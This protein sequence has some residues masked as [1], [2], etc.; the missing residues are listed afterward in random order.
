VT[1]AAPNRI[2]TSVPAGATTGVIHVVTP[3]GSADS[4]TPFTVGGDVTVSP[5]TVT[6]Y[7]TAS[8]QFA[9]SEGAS[10]TTTVTWAVNGITGG[11]PQIG[12]ITATGLYTAPAQ[13]RMDTDVTVAATLQDD[14]TAKATATV[15]LLRI[16]QPVAAAVSVLVAPLPV[17]VSQNLVAGV[18]VRVAESPTTLAAA[19][20]VGVAF[21]PVVTGVSP[22]SS[23]AG[24]SNL[25]MT[26]SGVGLTAATAVEFFRTNVAD[27]GFTVTNVSANAEGTE[28]TATVS[29]AGGAPSGPRV[30][31][32][33]TPGGAST[34]AGST[35]SLFSVP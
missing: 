26:I 14:R 20:I 28:V 15:R 3:L 30:V 33:T 1:A 11:E 6:L 32:V 34:L 12:T 29:I 7:L 22:A 13:F 10:P 4:P 16:T 2:T 24:T 19:P 9:A 27:T 23:A 17:S 8:Q 25:A 18:S 21:E 31:R 5:A 35:G